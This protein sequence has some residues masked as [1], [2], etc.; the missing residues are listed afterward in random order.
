[1]IEYLYVVADPC[2]KTCPTEKDQVCGSDGVTYHN[3]C[4]MEKESCLLGK[5][6]TVKNKG[7]CGKE[8]Q[9]HITSHQ[10]TSHNR[11]PLN[12]TQYCTRLHYTTQHHTTQHRTILYYTTPDP[13]IPHHSKALNTTSHHTIHQTIQHHTT[14]HTTTLL[15]TIIHHTTPHHNT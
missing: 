15:H 8:T 9:Q 4:E 1:M 3:L 2:A 14:S 6:I 12:K 5:T 13:T 11:T 10:I 7:E